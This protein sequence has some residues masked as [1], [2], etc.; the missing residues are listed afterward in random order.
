MTISVSTPHWDLDATLPPLMLANLSHLG[1]IKV[2]GEQGRSFIHGQVTTDISSLAT[3][4]WRWG[5]HCD[6]KGKMLASFRTFAIQDALFMLMPKDAIEVDLPQLQKYA[7]FSKATLS[8]ASAEW[9]LLGVAGEQAS[10]FVNKH[11]GDIQQELTLIE[12]GA[13]LKDAERFIL[14]LTPDAAAALVAQSELSVF[15]ASA[16]QALE[17]AAGYPNLAASHA[18]Q[19]VP[20]MC[21]LQAVNGIS[22]NK[23]CYMGQETI[24]RMKYRGGNKRAL[25]ILHG[26]TS[27]QI[28]LASGLEIAMEDSF[29]RGGQIIEFVQR[30]NQVLLTAVLPNDTANDT[31]LRFADDEQSHLTIQALPY[32]LDEA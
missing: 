16:W 26:H 28:T 9:T 12:N 31:Q 13:I 27:L 7:V 14:V 18:S 3:D 10:Q 25:Y 19:Y 1:L 32:S 15:D 11:F 6:P 30:G 20:Q 17:I 5:A 4:Q 22:F 29:R 24:A 23:G 21:N 8:N 2:V